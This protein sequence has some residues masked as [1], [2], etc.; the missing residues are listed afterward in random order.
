M[1]IDY[2]GNLDV[3][4]GKKMIKIREYDEDEIVT[5]RKSPPEVLLKNK[6]IIRVVNKPKIV[7]LKK[8]LPVENIVYK[9]TVI[10]F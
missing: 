5:L 4:L 10:I 7:Y 9:K 1:T 2:A 6:K 3:N 8:K